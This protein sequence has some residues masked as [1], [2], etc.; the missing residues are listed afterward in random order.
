MF[1]DCHWQ[2]LHLVGLLVLRWARQRQARQNQETREKS[3]EDHGHPVPFDVHV[4]REWRL[5]KG[6]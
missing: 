2:R 3:Y 6:K 1:G 4:S 5:S